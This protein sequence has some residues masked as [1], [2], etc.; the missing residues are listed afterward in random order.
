MEK[1]CL[2]KVASGE[3]YEEKAE[4]VSRIHTGKL[5]FHY[6]KRW[7]ASQFIVK[8]TKINP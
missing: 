8:A 6:M 7:D 3:H 4:H 2:T 5:I 1:S